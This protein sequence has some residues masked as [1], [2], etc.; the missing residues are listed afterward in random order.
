MT[1]SIKDRVKQS[2]TTT[3]TGT[4]TL[5]STPSGYQSFSSVFSNGDTVYYVI[6]NGSMYEI[7]VGTYSAGTLSRDTVL[8]SSSGTSLI[9]LSGRSTVFVAVPADKTI[10]ILSLIH[11]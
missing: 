6:E 11:I 9:T 2:T 5:S 7:G 3:G 10:Y 4:I 8:K 1:V